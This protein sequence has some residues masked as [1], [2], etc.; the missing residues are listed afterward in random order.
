MK[1]VINQGN[2]YKI[3]LHEV[4]GLKAAMTRVMQPLLV[5]LNDAESWCGDGWFKLSEAEYKS[6]DGFIPHTHNC[7]GLMIESVLPECGQSDFPSLNWPEYT[8]SEDGMTD[9]QQD[10]E[11]QSYA[12]NG[13][14]DCHLR[15]W[16]KFEGFDNRGNMQFYLVASSCDEAPYFRHRN[17]VNHFEASFTAATLSSFERK[18][19]VQ[20][21]KLVK[22][23]I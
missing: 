12:D 4:V 14:L 11:R 23:V 15:I 22:A 20:I 3:G 2:S 21:R 1:P 6:R 13:Y 19:A 9:D 17:A 5:A 7:G 8:P 16:L 18:A 10:E